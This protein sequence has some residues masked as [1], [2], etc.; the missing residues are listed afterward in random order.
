MTVIAINSWDD[1]SGVAN[2]ILEDAL[3]VVRETYE[4]PNHV[5]VFTDATGGN[6]RKGFDYNQVT[7]G[8]V[9]EYDDVTSSAF[10][11]TAGQTLTPYEY[12]AQLMISDLRRESETPE[13]IMTD[14]ARELGLAMG[15]VVQSNLLSDFTSLTGG[16]GGGNYYTGTII[17]T[18]SWGSLAGAISV[19]RNANKS[20]AVPL[21]AFIHGYSWKVLAASASVAGATVAAAPSFQDE[22]TRT[23]YVGMFDG[24]PI[25]QFYS[26]VTGTTATAWTNFAVFPRDAIA[27]DW[28][29]RPRLEPE[30]NASARGTEL[31]ISAVFAHGVWRPALGVYGKWFAPTP[32]A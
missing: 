30:R 11:A 27:L 15:D 20:S 10:A 5:K 21:A 26:S 31:N 7:I 2:S 29:R 18:A 14:S 9:T 3:F 24:V 32:T 8:T 17:G 28:R 12:A 19:A 22:I 16:S 4:L 1:L 23:G 25:Y 13:S 6:L